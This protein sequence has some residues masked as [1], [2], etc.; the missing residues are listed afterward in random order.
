[1]EK[2]NFLSVLSYFVS[3]IRFPQQKI[4][5][6]LCP[7]IILVLDQ[8]PLTSE[9]NICSKCINICSKLYKYFFLFFPLLTLQFDR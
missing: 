5:T 9:V 6:V 7:K 4:S 8:E 2:Y 3:Q 1:M